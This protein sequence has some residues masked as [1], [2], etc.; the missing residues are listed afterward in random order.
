MLHI[1]ANMTMSI[2]DTVQL[3]YSDDQTGLVIPENYMLLQAMLF[4]R[5]YDDALKRTNKLFNM[6]EKKKLLEEHFSKKD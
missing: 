6:D 4:Q 3:M 1:H 5:N 2:G